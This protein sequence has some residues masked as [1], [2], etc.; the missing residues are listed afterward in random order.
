[1]QPEFVATPRY[2]RQMLIGAE[3]RDA[4]DNERMDL[5]NPSTGTA[6][7]TVPC[8]SSQDIDLAV[9]AAQQ[10]FESRSW[11]GMSASVRAKMLWDIGD[12]IAREARELALIE[13]TNN[14][15]PIAMARHAVMDAVEFFRYYAGWCTKID[16]R[17]T[18]LSAPGRSMM[19]YTRREPLGVV[20]LIV[21]W[22]SP[23]GLAAMKLAPA[24]AAGCSCVLKPS[25]EAPLTALRLAEIMLE[26]GIPEGVLNVV[27]G[28]GVIVGAALAA[29]PQVAKISF[30]GSI[31]TGRSIIKAAAG[32]LKKVILGDADLAE[33]I[34]GATGGIYINSGQVC[35]AGSRLYAHRSVFDRVVEGIA[36][37]GQKMKIGRAIDPETEIGPLISRRQHQRVME[38]L[39]GAVKEGASVIAARQALPESGYYVEPSIVIEPHPLSRIV[40]EEVFG[41]VLTAMCFDDLDEV[42]HAANDTN[43]G[44]AAA[45]WT[46][47][48]SNAHLTAEKLQAGIVW[49]NCQLFA[50]IRMPFGGYKQS[51]WGREM[52]QDAIEAY[53][54]TKSVYVRL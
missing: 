38:F 7:G 52:A 21:P 13:S 9:D 47:D 46:R 18:D 32:N 19:G 29:H 31:E 4:V 36:E 16:G 28:K 37:A 6:I 45:V 1:M 39:D 17:M 26:C 27:T 41:P 33:A 43:Y 3:W 42:I 15:M 11:C 44:L 20:G 48:V 34:P 23:L 5:F 10:S 53:L 50:D 54:E 51:G 24:L 8:G 14:G 12:A 2:D 25:D 40:R 49:V 30:T 35:V 22:N